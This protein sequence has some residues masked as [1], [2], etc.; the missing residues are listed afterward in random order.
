M[1]Q[2]PQ[3]ITQ[4]HLRLLDSEPHQFARLYTDGLEPPTVARNS[5]AIERGKQFHQLLHQQSLGLPIAPLVD[6]DPDLKRYFQA[7]QTCPPPL[8]EGNRLAE[9]ALAL[10]WGDF[11]LYGIVDLLVETGEVV[12]A[13]NRAQIVDWKTYWR[14]RSF[15]ELVDD[16]QTRLYLFLLTE[17]RGYFPERVS[18]LYWFAE[19]PQH[20]IEISYSS[21]AHRNTRTDLA[22]LLDAL[23][24]WLQSGF[25]DPSI[26]EN[27][28][29]DPRSIADIPP[30]PL[31]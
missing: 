5:A 30:L 15:E 9:Y 4:S 13:D 21:E 20:C 29:F 12:E 1:G 3:R 11:Q 28:K 2:I 27:S 19:D 10:P 31:P 26:A 22:K 23:A 25:P 6:G 7:F 8:L 17:A 16:W 18:I 14:S 24:G